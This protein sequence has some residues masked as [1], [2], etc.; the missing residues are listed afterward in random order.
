M[1][2][3]QEIR[4]ATEHFFAAINQMLQGNAAPVIACWYGADD[5]T[6]LD[7]QGRLHR[8]HV[9]LVTYYHHAAHANAAGGPTVVLSDTITQVSR[10]L[11]FV[12]V[13]EQVTVSHAEGTSHAFIAH[14]TNGFRRE[15]GMWKV[16]HRHSGVASG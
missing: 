8:G 6:Y 5:V 3:T 7:P 12:V 16:I 10:D 11:A 15:D 13:R 2:D 9:A 14:S 4:T 1:T